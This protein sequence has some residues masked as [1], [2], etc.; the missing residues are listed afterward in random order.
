MS[1]RPRIHLAAILSTI[2]LMP[3]FS[4]GAETAENPTYRNWSKFKPKTSVKYKNTNKT[5]VMGNEITS[6][7][8][9]IMTLIEV[10]D[11]KV[12]IE[13]STVTKINGQEFKAPP[14]K[15]EY[16]KTIALKAGQTRESVR[17]PDSVFEEGKE[18]IKVTAGEYDTKWHK[19]RVEDRVLQSWVSDNVPGSLVKS[20]TTSDKTGTNVMELVEVKKP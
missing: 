14:T 9:V 1:P 15:Q 7:S 8:E 18:T 6:E 3:T 12:V 10:S 5:K 16:P 20:V 13:Y 11:N 4:F 2:L 17:K 19:S